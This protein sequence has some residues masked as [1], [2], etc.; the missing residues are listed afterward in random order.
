M[1]PHEP[2]MDS[3]DPQTYHLLQRWHRGDRVALD[4]ILQRDLP[5]IRSQVGR[6]LGDALRAKG[7]TQDFVQDAMMEV[8][9]YGP[10]FLMSDR[11]Q[12]RALMCRIIEN[13][14]RGKHDWFQAHRRQMAREKPLPDDSLLHLDPPDRSSVARPSQAAQAQERE[15]W[16]RMALE[17]LAPE[18]REVIL[19]RQWHEQS[20]GEMGADLGL[21][22]DAARMRYHRALPRLYRKIQQLRGGRIAEAL[23]GE[24]R[25]V[26]DGQ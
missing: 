3:S 9:R 5:W 11:S 12:F 22:E 10:R 25:E 18:D 13:V 7:E 19:R 2:S 24:E 6:R 26:K 20:F 4:E 1:A 8:L 16:V 21:S 23:A 15:A 17:L 14:L